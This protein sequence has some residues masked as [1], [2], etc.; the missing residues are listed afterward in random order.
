MKLTKLNDWLT[1]AANIGVIAGIVFLAMEINQ[2]NKVTIAATYQARISEIENSY[3]NTAL[4][5]Y[6]PAIYEKID[7]EGLDS[8]TSIELRRVCC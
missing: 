6:L 7:K 2:S 4:S 3:Q 5:D 1:L 8:I